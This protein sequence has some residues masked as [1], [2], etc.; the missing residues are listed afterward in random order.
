M[1]LLQLGE[2][3]AVVVSL[4]GVSGMQSILL[5]GMRLQQR[6]ALLSG[7]L[8]GSLGSSASCS[9]VGST[10]GRLL[11]RTLGSIGSRQR[12]SQVSSVLL[13]QLRE[14]SAMVIHLLGVGGV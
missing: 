10:L 4:L 7:A 13:L 12:R 1:L 3:S 11:S 5:I 6:L 2:S 14:R 8:G 9:L